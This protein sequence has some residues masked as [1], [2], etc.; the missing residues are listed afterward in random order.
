MRT[1][2]YVKEV[3]NCLDCPNHQVLLDPDPYDSFCR[4]D[5][6]VICNAA[7]DPR[8][9][10]PKV[11]TAGNRPYQIRGMATVPQWCPLLKES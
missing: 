5:E 9:L 3:D 11:V 2:K 7:L 6:K 4:D 8:T 10:T 1:V